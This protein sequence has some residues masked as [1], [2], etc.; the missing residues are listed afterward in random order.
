ML[1]LSHT[2]QPTPNPGYTAPDHVLN[3]H[4]EN[5]CL[6]IFL[7]TLWPLTHRYKGLAGDAG[8]YAVQALAKMHSNLAGDLFLQNNSQNNYTV[9]PLFYAWCVRWLGLSGAAMTLVIAFK[10]WFFAAAWALART[11]FDRRSAFLSSVVVMAIA[12]SYGG[13]SVFSYSEDWLTA[14]T[15][16][17]PMVITALWLYCRNLRASSF[18]VVFVALFVHPLMTLPALALLLLL[19]LPI[20]IGAA[21]AVLSIVAALS[22]AFL[23]LH[24]SPGLGAFSVMDAEWLEIV[25]ERSVFLF[26]QL[27]SAGDWEMNALPFV[28]LAIS[29]I[30]LRDPRIHKL[31]IAAAL[32]GVTGLVI[33]LVAGT[34][35][36]VGLFLQ[37]QAWRWVWITR[38]AAVILLAPTLLKLWQE[39]KCGPPCAVLTVL[40]WTFSPTEGL[41]Y[42]TLSLMFRSARHRM[43]PRVAAS[44]R[45]TAVGLVGILFVRI[46]VHSWSIVTSPAPALDLEPVLETNLRNILGFG[47][48]SIAFAWSLMSWLE[49]TASRVLPGSLSLL[50]FICCLFLYPSAFRV[51]MRE[52][53]AEQIAEFSDWRAAIAPN[54]SVFVV[55]AHNSAA[56]AWFTLER[57]SYLT[58]DQSAGAVFS[59]AT[60]L[61][62][63]RRADV[64]SP[65]MDPDWKL[66]SQRVS[67]SSGGKVAGKKVST[68]LTPDILS[69]ICSD[70]MLRFVVAR[71]NLGFH[72]I[73]H[74]HVG[75]W[76]DWN[77]YDCRTVHGGVPPA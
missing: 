13:Y 72:A 41:A 71:E 8:L 33:A 23:G 12:G 47:V 20:T 59:R 75:N 28:S 40:G 1:D 62:V 45:W 2:V 54:D 56:F 11:L 55:P 34:I 50:L 48:I 6:A 69:K 36:P 63:R 7:V 38:F 18:L 16:A 60:A 15:L 61:E 14:R 53:S 30:T 26:P 57:P 70:P 76:K 17:E 42:L 10:I 35:G 58:V 39:E 21:G 43:T 77:L 49:R 9:F 24:Q 51:H 5:V 68:P 4:I 19:S 31:C 25:R 29:A 46:V 44:C 27:W 66:L 3:R 37:G 67:G 22:A 74:S 73:T 65:L 52:G 32:V 64:L